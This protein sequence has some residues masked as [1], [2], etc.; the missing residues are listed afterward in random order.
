MGDVQNRKVCIYVQSFP[1]VELVCRQ[2]FGSSRFVI[3]GFS[4]SETVMISPA[5]RF[6]AISGFHFR[7]WALFAC[8]PTQ[9]RHNSL[10]DLVPTSCNNDIAPDWLPPSASQGLFVI[11]SPP[12]TALWF[13]GQVAE[14]RWGVLLLSSTFRCTIS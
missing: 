3:A 2:E 5:S 9:K 7:P 1:G 6:L 12:N 14:G 11:I 8:D 13:L 4:M 10:I